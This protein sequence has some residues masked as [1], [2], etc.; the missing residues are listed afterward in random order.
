MQRVCKVIEIPWVNNLL[1][2]KSTQFS[3]VAAF[4]SIRWCGYM[5]WMF[6]EMSHRKIPPP[7]DDS[8]A[9]WN[10]D[11]ELRYIKKRCRAS[12]SGRSEGIAY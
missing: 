8:T 3:R 9:K 10:E 11:C 7:H 5:F 4:W 2:Q 12:P 6:R 1:T